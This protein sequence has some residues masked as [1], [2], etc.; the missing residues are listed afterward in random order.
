MSAAAIPAKKRKTQAA[1]SPSPTRPSSAV[2]HEDGALSLDTVRAELIRQ[3]ETIIFALIERAQFARNAAVYRTGA[4]SIA[5][6]SYIY[7]SAS[8]TTG[9]TTA[10]EDSFLDFFLRRTEEL[11][12]LLGRFTSPDENPF[13]VDRQ[14]PALVKGQSYPANLKP[15]NININ[16]K[17]K[18]VFETCIL[19]RICRGPSESPSESGGND[20]EGGGGGGGGSG[21]GDDD[22]QYGSS[23]SCDIALL[24]ALSKR[25]HFGKFVAEA[26]F[27]MNRERYSD[28]IRANDSAG[29]MRELTKPEVEKR[30]VERV[31]LKASTYGRDPTA[32]SAAPVDEASRRAETAD[33]SRY[34]KTKGSMKI[35]PDEVGAIYRDYVMPLN[36]EVQVMYLLQRLGGP[37][38]VYVSNVTADTASAPDDAYPPASS[39]S[40]SSTSS[41]SS[42]SASASASRS[43]PSFSSSATSDGRAACADR[44]GIFTSSCWTTAVDVAT[45]LSMVKC[46]S[47]SHAMVRIEDASG[48]IA[49]ETHRELLGSGLVISAEVY[50]GGGARYIE[51]S[52]QHFCASGQ[53]KTTL[54]ISLDKDKPG[55]LSAILNIFAKAGI[56]LLLIS[57][58]RLA[59]RGSGAGP[60]FFVEFEGHISSQNVGDVLRLV[61]EE[62]QAVD[63]LGSYAKVV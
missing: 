53:D 17:V 28:M 20:H 48:G 5:P 8:S 46:N 59:P 61:R 15:N 51:V 32:D 18:S 26:K 54:S 39:S 12:A 38:A 60:H 19:P 52:K 27:L 35:E 4:G 45:A 7:S 1:P 56:N 21:G 63:F 6:S 44:F 9:S 16:A 36:K 11:H 2:W 43:S 42:S 55:A 58:S 40:S 47:V 23:A 41:S 25:I 37:L 33:L 49:H 10:A 50:V 62:A 24:Q 3:E 13:L 30:V 31:A 29:L 57:S 14:R 22:G 34:K